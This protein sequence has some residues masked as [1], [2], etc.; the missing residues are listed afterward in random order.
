[1]R[2]RSQYLFLNQITSILLIKEIAHE[3]RHLFSI[4]SLNRLA[5]IHENAQS[6]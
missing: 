1:M 3:G 4:S 6:R 5:R 2:A